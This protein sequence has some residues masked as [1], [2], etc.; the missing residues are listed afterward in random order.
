MNEIFDEA[1]IARN[2]SRAARRQ[3]DG[4]DFLLELTARE[5]ADRLSIVERQFDRAVE[6]FGGTGATAKAALAT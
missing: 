5:L 4:A 3:V 1:L 6:L 2:R